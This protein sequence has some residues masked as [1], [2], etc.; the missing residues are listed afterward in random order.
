MSTTIKQ[1]FNNNNILTGSSSNLV[2]T[3]DMIRNFGQ[4]ED[5][6][7]MILSDPANKVLN[8]IVPFSNYTIPGIFQPKVDPATIQELI[9][10]PSTDLKNLGIRSGDYKII[11]NIL[12]PVIV[13]SYNPS[14]FIKE[15]SGDRTEIRLTTNNIPNDE[16]INNTND[17]IISFQSVPYFKEF[18]LNFGKNQLYPAVNVALDLGSSTVTTSNGTGISTLSGSPTILIKLLNPLPIKYK[19]NDLLNVVDEIANPQMFEATIVPDA[20][21]VTYP[22][23]RGP[24][25]DLD[26]D[27]VR[28]GPTPYYNFN[29]ITSFQGNFAPQLQQLLGQLSASNFQINVDYTNYEDFI[30]FSSAARRLEG[31]KYKLSNIETYA[32]ASASAAASNSPT[33]YTDAQLYQNNIDKAIQGFDGYEQ[34]LYYESSSYSWPKQNSTKPY[35]IQSITSSESTNWYSG[36]YNSSSLYDDNNQN[37]ILYTLPGYIAENTSNELAFEFVASIGQMF[38]DIWIHI[39][40]I[41]DLYQAKNALTEGISKD[42]VYFALQSMGINVYTDENGS[43]VFKYLYGVDKDG[44][45][46]P[47][48]GSYDTLIS[49]SNYQI[50]GQDQQKGIYKRLY[51]NLPLLLKSKGTNRF[52]Q[53]LNT[54]FGIPSTIMSYIEYGGVDKVTSSF[55][56]EYDKFTYGL[57]VTSGER[58]TIP[59]TYLSQSYNKTGYN[60]IVPN[61]IELRL[62]T[63]TTSSTGLSLNHATQSLIARLGGFYLDLIY[64]QTGSDDSIYSGSIGDFGYFKFTLGS[65]SVNSPT[66]PIFT[67]GSDGSTSWYNVLIQ[68]RYPNKRIGNISDDQYYDLYIKNNVYGEIG[69]TASASLYTNTDNIHW[70]SQAPYVFIGYGFNQFSGSFQE[71][72]LWSNYISE[73][74]FNSHVLNP[75]SIEGNFTTSSFV[76]LTARWPLG[77]NLYTYNHYTT[78]IL[79]SVHP[80]QKTQILDA[81][82][83]NFANQ[84]NYSSFTETYYADVANSGYANPVTDKVRII[85]GSTYGKQ[86]MPNKSIEIKPI[87]PLTKDIHL[88]DASL[89]PQDE[90]DR[91]I[92]SQFG[93]T[94]NLDDIIGDPATGSYQQ[95]QPLQNNFFKKFNNK[96]N[97]K[98]YI[99]LIS[100]FHNSLFRTL[101]DFTPARTNLSTGIVIKPHLLERSMVLRPEPNF[102]H[103]EE[104]GYIDTAFITS[105]NGGD[106]SQSLYQN[107]VHGNIGPVTM[108]SDAR[109]F[110][111]G[112]LPSSSIIVYNNDFQY[113]PFNTFLPSNLVPYSQSIWAH[114]YN[115][116]INNVPNSVTSSIRRKIT[117]ITS[118]SQ[119]IQVLEPIELQDFTYQYLRHARPRYIGSQVNSNEY[120]FLT[121]NEYFFSANGVGSF[122]KNAAI[123]KN[124]IQFA[125]F[126]EATCDGPF[127]IAM[128]D[129]TNLYIKYLINESGSLTELAQRDYLNITSNQFYNLY[130]VQN[131]F[132]GSEQA[133]VSL[134]DNQSPSLQKTLDGNKLIYNS[135]YKCYP[136]LWR[137]AETNQVYNIPSGSDSS[138]GVLS[139]NSYALSTPA[140]TYDNNFPF[141]TITK[142]EGNIR[143]TPGILLPYDI[144]IKVQMN[145]TPTALIE[146]RPDTKIV[147]FDVLIPAYDNNNNPNYI[148]RYKSGTVSLLPGLTS[149]GTIQGKYGIV[150]YKILSVR[151]SNGTAANFAY[152]AVDSAAYLTVDSNDRSIVSCSLQMTNYY[153]DVMYFSSSLLAGQSTDVTNLLKIYNA[154]TPLDYSFKINPGDVIRFNYT[155]SILPTSFFRGIDEYTVLY[156]STGSRLAFKL[157][158]KV[159]DNVT[160][161]VNPYRIERYVFSRKIPDETNIIIEHQKQAGLTS[162]GIVKN[163]NL[164]LVIDDKVANIVSELKS[165]IFSTVLT[166]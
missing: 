91:N 122:G 6:V 157:D 115:P 100:F 39:K 45:Y 151:P 54:I 147:T 83:F 36:S 104:S 59:W 130:Q 134:F 74:A 30:H 65:N 137:V 68:R 109:D 132:K 136:V 32:S 99:R 79:A 156:V 106:Y 38:D 89:S 26:L 8:T 117:Y 80:D 43:N 13:K 142:I 51:H 5:Y 121:D 41:G 129:R 16:I 141:P 103:N 164:S 108:I 158:R 62:K 14:L 35:I 17:F 87:I 127:K 84:N 44:N 90:I 161:S 135:G 94:Y 159:S 19:V 12:R 3:R 18:Y 29:Q 95:F 140:V 1:I 85:S 9:F 60:D 128:P 31:F 166:T 7:E 70:Y 55:E 78:L 64:T 124:T 165:K 23:L 146:F 88:F 113:N 15:I 114:D 50:P 120:N 76:D 119:S 112:E 75:E 2:V 47:N 105:S 77:N 82:F 98:D 25:F 34:Y 27:N 102:T 93:S 42:L 57:N 63:Y 10:D 163:K 61:G 66:V 49:A 145:L 101:K 133:N 67:T 40:A 72:R 73:S 149:F 48:T 152:T 81:K 126:S 28:V 4:P 131:I 69:H 148:G 37:Y 116:L 97:Y 21:S 155:S 46:L 150:S 162:G 71:L 33:A 86:L 20:I 125:Y 143:Y 22:T 110:F 58:I 92:I 118:G 123:D 56:Y 53:Y 139:P 52:N 153:N 107:T 24:N 111:I 11:Y 138:N 154:Y 144:V 96:Y 160:S